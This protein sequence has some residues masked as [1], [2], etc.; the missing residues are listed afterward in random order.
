MARNYAGPHGFDPLI[1]LQKLDIPGIWLL[2]AKDNSIST[3]LV[4]EI[5]D[6]L[7]A[8]HGKDFSYIVYPNKGHSWEDVDTNQTYPVLFDALNWLNEQFGD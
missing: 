3:P 5:L 1:S 2:G 7:I 8:D 4:I 6:S